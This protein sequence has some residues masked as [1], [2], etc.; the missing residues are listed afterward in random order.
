LEETM[1]LLLLAS[2]LTLLFAV[3]ATAHDITKGTIQI[4]HPTILLPPKG[5]K[6]AAGYMAISNNGDTSDRLIGVETPLAGAAKIHTSEFKDGVARMKHVPSLEIPADDTLIF[7]PGGLHVMFMGLTTVLD[8]DQM[9]PATLIFEKAGSVAIE[10]M[11]D[12][13]RDEHGDHSVN[14]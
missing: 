10:F 12:D 3:P 4:I 9:Y 1:R 8:A 7:E 2:A 13:T 5:A 6:A 14:E 11:I